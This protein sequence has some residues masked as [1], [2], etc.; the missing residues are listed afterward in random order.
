LKSANDVVIDDHILLAILLGDEPS[1]LRRSAGR[2]VT[3]GLF[4]HRLCR[5]LT[6]TAV[7]GSLSRSLGIAEPELATAAVRAA[8]SL[9]EN[10]GLVSLRDLAWPMANLLADG[11]RLN[12][13]AL[14]ALA[15]AELLGAE[16]CLAAVDDNPTLRS[17][18]EVRGVAVRLL[19][20]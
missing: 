6:N 12:L 10:I 16:L 19:G 14:E 15:A 11:V 20:S 7:V 4:Y 1:G 18:A 9:P 5:A 8:S 2:L 17:A 3:T 13:L